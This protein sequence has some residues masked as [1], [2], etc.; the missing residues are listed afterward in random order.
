MLPS[1]YTGHILSLSSKHLVLYVLKGQILERGD[2]NSAR[3]WYIKQVKTPLVLVQ[4][5]S[6]VSELAWILCLFLI[7]KGT[8]QLVY[9]IYLINHQINVHNREVVRIFLNVNFTFPKYFLL[10]IYHP[11]QNFF[12]PALK[13]V[14]LCFNFIFYAQCVHQSSASGL[15]Q[16][17]LFDPVR[18]C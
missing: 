8:G 5:C 3:I 17:W 2:R 12:F 15:F 11:N 14:I 4:L 18:Y 6:H 7:L 9:K 16:L 13:P 1:L 10:V